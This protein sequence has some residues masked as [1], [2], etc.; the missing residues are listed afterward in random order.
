MT[1]RNLDALT[2]IREDTFFKRSF[3]RSVFNPMKVPR[4]RDPFSRYPQ[5]ACRRE[6]L[7]ILK[8]RL[9]T[10][11]IAPP[12]PVGMFGL[13]EIRSPKRSKLPQQRLKAV[14]DEKQRPVENPI[15]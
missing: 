9:P 1:N 6:F 13:V 14:A 11:R 10:S 12:Q 7:E 3:S 5:Q 15:Q 4:D 8:E 2:Q